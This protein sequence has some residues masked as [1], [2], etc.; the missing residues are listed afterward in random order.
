MAHTQFSI[1]LHSSLYRI[2]LLVPKQLI[3]ILHILSQTFSREDTQLYWYLK[4]VVCILVKYRQAQ[5]IKVITNLQLE[6]MA[7]YVQVRREQ[8]ERIP[9]GQ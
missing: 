6:I 5:G 4:Q 9:K 3:S 7:K 8:L 1:Q 2:S